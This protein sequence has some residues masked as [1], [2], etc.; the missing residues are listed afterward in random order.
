MKR[1][2]TNKTYKQASVQPVQQL[3][4]TKMLSVSNR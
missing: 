1:K 3:M 2:K 4:T